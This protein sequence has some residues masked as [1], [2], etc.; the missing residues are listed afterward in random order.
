MANSKVILITGATGFVGSC[1][2]HRLVNSNWEVHVT[3]REQSN[4]WRI[5]DILGRALMH[6]IDIIDCVNLEKLIKDIKPDVI[7]HLAGQVAMT[8]SPSVQ[9]IW[10]LAVV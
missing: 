2:M 4:I 8:T 5:K 6:N 3:K 10:L 7:F 1:L 9:L